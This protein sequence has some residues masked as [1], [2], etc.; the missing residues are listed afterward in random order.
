[1]KILHF[2]DVH[3]R[4]KDIEEIE[5]CLNHI[6]DVARA[7]TPDIIINAGDTFDSQYVKM[8]SR[9]ALIIFN[10]FQQL[11][12]IAP[13]VI[14]T[15]TPS[16][17]STTVEVLSYIKARFPVHVVSLWPEQL[18]MCEGD[19]KADIAKLEAPDQAPVELVISMCP[20]PTKQY[21]PTGTGI[22]ETDAT[23]AN[24]MSK[25]F[26]GFA[27]RAEPFSLVPHVLVGHWNT[28]GAKIAE[29]QS[30]T[31]VDIEISRDQ[32]GLSKADAILLGH[33]HKQQQLGENIFYSGDIT[34]LTWGEMDAK[35][36]YIHTFDGK[37]LVDSKF[38][39]TPAI[40]RRKIEE[41]LTVGDAINSVNTTVFHFEPAEILDFFVKLEFKVYQDEADKIDTEMVKDIYLKQ[42]AKK[43]EIDLIRIPRE[44]VRSQKIL[45]LTT[46]RDKLVEQASLKDEIVTTS[47]LEKADMLE[48]AEPD[49]IIQNVTRKG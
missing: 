11:A 9:S 14:I 24:E 34:S 47:I 33:I 28:T 19:I 10:T 5:K 20:A 49:K 35:G 12:N 29:T 40:K 7:E 36:F 45:Q 16:H 13:V 48:A 2:A 38:I 37:K 17:D 39:T 23:I 42:G 30:L 27:A 25:I 44:N 22:Q 26:A 1:M 8:D 3:A 31:G 32:M 18:Y 41:D 43:V 46:L 4:N 21:L 6:I 15:G